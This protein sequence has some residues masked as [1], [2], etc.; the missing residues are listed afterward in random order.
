MN[1]LFGTGV[2]APVHHP[3]MTLAV[4]ANT[5]SQFERI[6][7]THDELTPWHTTGFE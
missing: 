3:A 7:I 6:T 4:P 1:V 5:P 2:S